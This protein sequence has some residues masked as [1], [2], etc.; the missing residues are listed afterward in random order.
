MGLM[1]L[2]WQEGYEAVKWLSDYVTKIINF[3]YRGAAVVYGDPTMVLHPFVMMVREPDLCTIM[4]ICLTGRLHLS[5][6]LS[7]SLCVCVFLRTYQYD[8]R[9]IVYNIIYV[10]LN[11]HELN[12]V[13]SSC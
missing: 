7:L 1:V 8:F 2:Q 11:I 12:N 13:I 10:I 6:S 3:G 4:S 5:L 9:S